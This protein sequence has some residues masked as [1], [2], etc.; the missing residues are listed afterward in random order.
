MQPQEW[1]EPVEGVATALTVSSLQLRVGEPLLVRLWIRND[2][3]ASLE[4]E[5]D[6]FW[7][8]H[9]LLMT[10][11][12]GRSAER[13]PRGQQATDAFL[14]PHKRKHFTHV[15]EPGAVHDGF[16]PINLQDHFR[17]MTGESYTVVCESQIGA[18]RIWSNPVEFDVLPAD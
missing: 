6:G 17:I 9:R 14:R 15:L 18:G 16:E 4:I 5:H 12:S 1:G 10:D 7:P 8:S 11:R 13:T 3:P 2:S